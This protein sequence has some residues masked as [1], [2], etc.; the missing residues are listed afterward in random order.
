MLTEMFNQAIRAWTRRGDDDDGFD[1]S[2]FNDPLAL[3]QRVQGQ[4]GLSRQLPH[5]R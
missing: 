4:P 2:I 3:A 1:P 5:R